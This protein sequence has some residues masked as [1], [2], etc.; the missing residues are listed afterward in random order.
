MNWTFQS[1][2]KQYF[3]CHL[4]EK[5]FSVFC[6]E[7]HILSDLP[8]KFRYQLH[9][10]IWA[11]NTATVKQGWLMDGFGVEKQLTPCTR[12][13]RVRAAI[14]SCARRV[15][16]DTEDPKMCLHAS[17]ET[18]ATRGTLAGPDRFVRGSRGSG[19][20]GDF[21]LQQRRQRLNTWPRPQMESRGKWILS[22]NRD[23][24]FTEKG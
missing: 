17:M 8:D 13:Y 23:V 14:L 22:K 12:V 7:N 20:N 24:V 6:P 16:D 5:H 10:M 11:G 18:I 3:C 21:A 4:R 1:E 15:A 19:S 2:I 9:E